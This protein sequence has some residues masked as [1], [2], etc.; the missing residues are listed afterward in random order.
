MLSNCCE[1]CGVSGG[2]HR[3]YCSRYN[4]T[5]TIMQQV[6]VVNALEKIKRRL[7][8]NV[9]AGKLELAELILNIRNSAGECFRVVKL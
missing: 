2:G 9:E 8:E 6:A 1:E 5:I 3:K 7:D 4:K